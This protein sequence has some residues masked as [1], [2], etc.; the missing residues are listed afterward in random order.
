MDEIDLIILKRLLENSRLTYREL[1]EMTNMSVSVIH[2]RI[3][4]LVDD[5]IIET[6][7]ARPSAFIHLNLYFKIF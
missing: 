1:A 5:E 2:K 7:I 4:K 3:N 6:F